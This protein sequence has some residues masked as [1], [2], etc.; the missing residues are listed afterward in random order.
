MTTTTTESTN[1]DAGSSL[2]KFKCDRWLLI[3]DTVERFFEINK[4]ETKII[5]IDRTQVCKNNNNNSANNHKKTINKN[6]LLISM[7]ITN[8]RVNLYLFSFISLSIGKCRS[9][10]DTDCKWTHKYKDVQYLLKK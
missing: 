6:T 10:D 2:S 3:R 7:L 9:T 8:S 1:Y 4:T 5:K